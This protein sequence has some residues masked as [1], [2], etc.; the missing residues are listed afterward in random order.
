M[1]LTLRRVEDVDSAWPRVVAALREHYAGDPAQMRSAIDAG[2]AWLLAAADGFV[3]LSIEHNLDVGWNELV[4]WFAFSTGQW[5]IRR[6]ASEIKSIARDLG[7]RGI[8]TRV[9]QDGL[10]K[11]LPRLGMTPRYVEFFMEI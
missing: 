9:S 3:V 4:V 1:S 7:C 6:Y 8:V 11:A 10:L 2:R 5:G